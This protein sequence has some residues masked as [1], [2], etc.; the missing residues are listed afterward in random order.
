MESRRWTALVLLIALVVVGVWVA[1]RIRGQGAHVEQFEAEHASGTRGIVQLFKSPEELP[2][3]TMTDLDG[4]SHSSSDWRGKVVLIN[5]WATWC[6]PCRA[7]IPDLIALQ[8]KYHDKLVIIGISED[9]GTI[10]EVRR[11]ADAQGVN[12]PIV[13][14]TPE[15]RKTFK[16][17]AALPTTFVLDRDG[18]LAQRHVGMLNPARTEAETRVLA[19]LDVNAVVERIENNEKVRLESAAQA[20]QL[21]GVDLTR[22]NEAQKKAVL[23][24]L[25]SEDCTCGC[26]LTVAVCRLDDPT[27]PVSLPMAQAI[28]KTYSAIQ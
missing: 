15:L 25:L 11:F 24:A 10:E 1:L 19:G 9:E 2:P 6:P 8:K 21:P 28:V 22:L 3:L 13:M 17:V 16:G 14:T 12:Y 20:K 18:R 4:R 27:C 23:Q 5:F 26:H 7:E